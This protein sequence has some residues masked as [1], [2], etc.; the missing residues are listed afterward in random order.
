MAIPD[1]DDSSGAAAPRRRRRD[2]LENRARLLA[3]AREVFVERG[4]NVMLEEI[5]HHAGVGVATMYRNFPSRP[6]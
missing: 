5:A 6:S 1:T 4:L 2:A 3:A